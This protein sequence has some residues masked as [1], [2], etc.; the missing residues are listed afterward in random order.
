M[1][2]KHYKCGL[3]VLLFPLKSQLLTAGFISTEEKCLQGIQSNLLPAEP[4][5]TSEAPRDSLGIVCEAKAEAGGS[6][7]HRGNHSA[8]TTA[9]EGAGDGWGITLSSVTSE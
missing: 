9:A 3:L 1:A 7:Q 2:G 8:G 5:P 4:P 6:S